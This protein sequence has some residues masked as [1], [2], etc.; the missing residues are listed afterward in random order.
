MILP[1]P[2]QAHA[3][4][5]RQAA[6]AGGA[7]RWWGR[8]CFLGFGFLAS[9]AIAQNVEV[10]SGQPITL[11]EVLVDDTPGET[12]VRFRF[13]APEIAETG[14]SVDYETAAADMDHLCGAFALSYMDSYDLEAI[15]VV[16]S[17]SDRSVAFG[18]SDP[19]A[20]QFFEAY[21]PEN[22]RCIWEEL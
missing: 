8:G 18:E 7:H 11:V 22:G 6:P 16:I 14:G 1:H 17:L 5:I 20:T 2:R 4:R 10:P 13:L 3:S 12:W 21:R 19:E 15:R 9:M